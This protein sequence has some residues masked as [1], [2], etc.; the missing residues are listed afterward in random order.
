LLR[1]SLII[2]SGSCARNIAEDLLEKGIEIIIAA[3]GKEPDLSFSNHKKETF[4]EILTQTRLLDCRGSVGKFTVFMEQKDQK[5]ERHVANIIIAEENRR[6]QNFFLYDLTASSYVLSLS[7]IKE[8][9]NS[10]DQQDIFPNVTKIMFLTGLSVESNPVITKEIMLFSLTLQSELK[11]Q[12]YILTRNLKVAGDG[13]EVLYRKTKDA[14]VA[15]VK[16]SDTVPSI[17]QEEDGRVGIEFYDEITRRQFRLSPDITVVDETIM[18]SEYLPKLANTLK[19]DTDDAGFVQTDNVHRISVFTNRKGIIAA[20]PARAVQS[21]VDAITDASNAALSVI[22]LIE[23]KLP[24]SENKAE[25]DPG[26]CVRCL[27]CYR[28]C[29]YRAILLDTKPAVVPEACEGCGICAAECPRDTIKIKD[30]SG[31]DIS[32][33]ILKTG[34][35]KKVKTFIPFIVA[36]CCT[37]SAGRARELVSGTGLDLPSGLKIIEC[38]CSG[39]ISH[40]HIFAA[41]R[42]G[43]DGV[44]VLACHEGNCHSEL[45]NIYARQRVNRVCDLLIQVGFEKERLVVKTL[46]ANMPTEFSQIA[47]E[48]EK[49]IIGLG[50]SRLKSGVN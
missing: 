50:A 27:T 46:A 4:P 42:N 23:E 8:L 9:L 28:L 1:R 11:K 37:R 33:E 43:A 7:R 5:I 14:G 3:K 30:L 36:F 2:G 20:G 19:I 10:H 6:E 40:D 49:Q 34:F 16:F 17:D 29:P 41:F 25:I 31:S 32:D 38:P 45:G 47:V 21:D 44:M 35:D 24:A 22:E 12:I 48:F 26:G 15:Y 13:L 18:P 39:G